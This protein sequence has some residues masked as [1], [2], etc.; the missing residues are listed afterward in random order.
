MAFGDS[1]TLGPGVKPEESY[2]AQLQALLRERAGLENLAVVNAGIGGNTAPQGLARLDKDVLAHKPR[3]VL[4]GFGMNDSVMTAAGVVRVPVERFRQTLTEMVLRL[5][6]AGAKVFLAPVTPVI[7]QYYWERHPREW[8]PEG[9][10]PQLDRYTAAIREVGAQTGAAVIDLGRL[11]PA[12][13]IR[14]P[15]NSGARD[16]VHPTAA[17]YTVLATAYA[18]KLLPLAP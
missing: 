18:D 4:I 3:A 8:Y 7:E 9:L 11:D 15:E 1:I 13:H 10:K 2:P 16:G 12:E 5:Q 17:G 6:A 14:T